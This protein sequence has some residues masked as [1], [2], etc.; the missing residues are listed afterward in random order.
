MAAAR[1]A[2]P[3][4]RLEVAVMGSGLE[5]LQ[6]VDVQIVVD[7]PGELRPDP[8][9]CLEQLDRVQ[10]AAQPLQLRPA[11]GAQDLMDGGGDTFPDMG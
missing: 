4:N 7:A 11:T 3:V 1:R 8:G 6:G 2:P 5:G 10:R 9:D